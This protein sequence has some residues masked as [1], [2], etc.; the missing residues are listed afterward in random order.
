[1]TLITYLL[2]VTVCMACFFG[3]YMIAL[4]RETTFRTNRAY[5]ISTVLISL[6]LPWIKIYV[7][8]W[9]AKAFISNS[10]VFLGS[11]VDS[12]QAITIT[13]PA[14][15]SLHWT[16]IFTA[17]YFVFALIF[18]I[19]F[20][21]EILKIYNI[22]R[23][24]QSIVV[25]GHKCMLSP[26][27]KT[28]FSFF[29][30][31]YLPA[32]HQFSAEELAE[33]IRHERS[34]IIGRHSVD[35][36]L[37][38]MIG[39]IL[40]INP[41]VY[42][43][44]RKLRELH[45]Y[46]A[47]AEVIRHHHWESY[48]T[49]LISQKNYG[50]QNTLSNQLVY[51]QLKNRLI[52]MTKKPSSM[53]SKIKYAGM[54][55]ILMIALVLFSF[56][57]KS[58]EKQYDPKYIKDDY[59]LYEDGFNMY[60]PW[61]VELQTISAEDNTQQPLFPGC[62]KVPLMEQKSCSQSRLI[63]FIGRELKYPQQ[64][65]DENITGQV[66]VK[67]TVGANGL[68]KEP[69]IEKS[70]HAAADQAVLNVFRL[71]NGKAGKWT[72]GRKE[73][74]VVS[75]EMILPISFA[76]REDGKDEAYTYVEEMPRFPGCENQE[77]DVRFKCANEKMYKYFYESIKYPKEDRDKGIQGMVIAQFVV[78]PDGSISDIN[79]IKGVSPGIDTEVLRIVESMNALPERWIPGRDKG[80]AVPVTFTVP[81]KF[82]FQ[83]DQVPVIKSDEVNKDNDS[84]DVAK[85][86]GE[87]ST[88]FPNPATGKITVSLFEGAHMI[89]ILDISGRT[90]LSKPITSKNSISEEID[91][92]SLQ[93][94][95]Y[96][97]QIVSDDETKSMKF[98][99]AKNE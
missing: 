12:F 37:M 39:V 70:L 87:G 94:G 24:G 19:R 11:Y 56:R 78:R 83:N 89:R 53:L 92:K 81:F 20:C 54:L 41:M 75:M 1:M 22:Y 36:I 45:E 66:Y 38:E 99:K 84:T 72:P 10:Q 35:I 65:I 5:L 51:S 43:Y 31:I 2:Q 4:Q 9:S 42:L 21:V 18:G 80:I 95:N 30:T 33:V 77:E 62:D 49:F 48:A 16:E 40:W 3:F 34:H 71:L 50:L 47:D 97:L 23:T 58:I 91:I 61:G 52:M 59:H 85:H 25:R 76:E 32:A 69:V 73:G 68:I 74:R 44:R 8:L 14:S 86:A 90:I 13:A 98:I 29:N 64:L 67:F 82:V 79:I 17:G 60:T 26:N 27:V 46:L 6:I 93:E 15:Y 88:L 57:E 55:P 28:P 96:I 7:D 63:E